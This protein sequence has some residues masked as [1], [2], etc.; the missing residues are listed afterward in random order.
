MHNI[1][2]IILVSNF[3]YCDKNVYSF[4]RISFSQNSFFQFRKDTTVR[5]VTSVGRPKDVRILRAFWKCKRI[6]SFA[7]K[8]RKYY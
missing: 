7:S 3:K 8:K 4:V 6:S 1:A 2:Q 5:I